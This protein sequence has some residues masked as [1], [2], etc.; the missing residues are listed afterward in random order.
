MDN[1]LRSTAKTS[2][3][4]NFLNEVPKSTVKINYFKSRRPSQ[5]LTTLGDESLSKKLLEVLRTPP[6]TN[7]VSMQNAQEQQKQSP[8]SHP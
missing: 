3:S 6:S 7:Q 5:R 2:K 4:S 8:T 1:S